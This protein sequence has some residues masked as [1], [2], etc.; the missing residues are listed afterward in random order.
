MKRP[1]RWS[2]HAVTERFFWTVERS[3][4]RGKKTCKFT[5]FHNDNAND[6]D[7]SN[8]NVNVNDRDSRT[9]RKQKNVFR[10]FSICL[11]LLVLS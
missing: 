6:N 1:L 3:S 8:D 7:N 2:W 10:D 9:K 4:H 5:T 11:K